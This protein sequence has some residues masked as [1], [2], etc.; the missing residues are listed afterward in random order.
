MCIVTKKSALLL[1][2]ITIIPDA[3]YRIEKDTKIF[4]NESVTNLIL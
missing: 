1:C 3:T 4:V 2:S